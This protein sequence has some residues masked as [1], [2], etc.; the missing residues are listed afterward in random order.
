MS[1]E[2]TRREQVALPPA[3]LLAGLTNY[4]F[5]V[6]ALA[7]GLAVAAF[8]FGAA[9]FFVAAKSFTS[10]HSEGN[11]SLITRSDGFR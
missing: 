2:K 8:F 3:V 4:F 7:F 6:A 1:E 5:L 11:F 9:F 10:F